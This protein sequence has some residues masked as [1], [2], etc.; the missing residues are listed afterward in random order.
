MIR[1]GMATGRPGKTSNILWSQNVQ[2]FCKKCFAFL[3]VISLFTVKPKNISE[4]LL[5]VRIL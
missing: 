4:P 5:S 1:K 3:S 2:L